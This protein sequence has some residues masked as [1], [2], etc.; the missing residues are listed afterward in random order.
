MAFR[1]R[2]GMRE[3]GLH[4]EVPKNVRTLSGLPGAKKR[5]SQS[6]SGGQFR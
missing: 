3:A 1:P 6:S 5:L 4:N 2:A